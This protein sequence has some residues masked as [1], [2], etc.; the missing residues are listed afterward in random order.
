MS[1]SATDTAILLGFF[2]FFL[3]LGGLLPFLNAEFYQTNS[4]YAFKIDYSGNILINFLSV[5]GSMATMFFWSFG[6]LPFII[7]LLMMIPRVFFILIIAKFIRGV[8]S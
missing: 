6:S 3:L 8:S 7:D 2:T 1:V 4:S 5:I